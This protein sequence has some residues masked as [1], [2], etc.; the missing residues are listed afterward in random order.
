[1]KPAHTFTHVAI[2][3][4]SLMAGCTSQQLYNAGQ[5]WQ[6]NW[7]Y[8]MIEQTDRE[9]CLSKTNMSY[10]DYK[11]QTDDSKKQ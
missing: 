3:V 9:R 1:M 7:C 8:R 10:E 6:R 11:R 5:S 2:L 4:S